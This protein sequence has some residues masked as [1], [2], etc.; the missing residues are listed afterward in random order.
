VN[1]APPLLSATVDR[2]AVASAALAG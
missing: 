1:T 2:C